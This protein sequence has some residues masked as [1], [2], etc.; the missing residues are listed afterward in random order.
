MCHLWIFNKQQLLVNVDSVC[1]PFKPL[2]L[3]FRALYAYRCFRIG[4]ILSP[5]SF[6]LL[7]LQ[8]LAYFPCFSEYS[9][10]EKA[11][12]LCLLVLKSP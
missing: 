2:L 10:E 3:Q 1:V 12:V 8:V 6:F 11:N 9:W 5:F 7:F 4:E